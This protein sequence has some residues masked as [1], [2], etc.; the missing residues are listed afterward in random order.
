MEARDGFGDEKAGPPPRRRNPWGS[1]GPSGGES[2]NEDRRAMAEA[3][4]RSWKLAEMTHY[5]K[6]RGNLDLPGGKKLARQLPK[7]D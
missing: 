1:G 6:T 5:H 3:D 7:S 4:D 2:I